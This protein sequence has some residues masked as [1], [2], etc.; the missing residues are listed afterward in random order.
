MLVKAIKNV[1]GG[2]PDIRNREAPESETVLGKVRVP[3]SRRPGSSSGV[4]RAGLV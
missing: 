1:T 2:T 4:P 3:Y